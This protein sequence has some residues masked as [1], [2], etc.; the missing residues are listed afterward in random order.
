MTN[1]GRTVLRRLRGMLFVL[2]SFCACF[3]SATAEEAQHRYFDGLRERGLYLIAEDYAVSRLSGNR[4]LPDERAILTAEL[5]HT[6]I[7][8]GALSTGEQRHELWQEAERLL[9]DFIVS[10]PQ[11][12]R[13]LLVQAAA[14]MLPARMAETLAWEL[15]VNPANRQTAALAQQHASEAQRRLSLL[16]T[17]ITSN[18][19]KSSPQDQADGALSSEEALELQQEVAYRLAAS[20]FI[21][22]STFPPGPDRAGLLIETVEQFKDLGNSRGDSIWT[23]RATI[24]RAKLARLDGDFREAE[25]LLRS[26]A[27]TGSSDSLEDEILAEQVRVQ[28]AQGHPDQGLQDVTDRIR[29]GVP[30]AD[31]LRAVAVEG[32]LAAW[33]IAGQKGETEFQQELLREAQG[34]YELTRGKWQQLTAYRLREVQQDLELGDELAALVREANEYF[35]AGDLTKSSEL[36]GNAAAIAHRQK[37]ADL[38]V[39]YAMT[40]GSIE[41]QA[42]NWRVAASNFEQLVIMYSQHAK[43]GDADLMKCYCLGQLYLNQ[44]SQESRT[45]YESAL[46]EHRQK[47]SGS[48]SAAE[49]TWML[50]AHQ[51]HRLQW[52]EALELYRQIPPA[53]ARYDAAML[54]VIILYEKILTRLREL[55]GDVTEWEDRILQEIV[56]IEER[57]PQGGLLKS[58]EQCQTSLR[59]AQLLLQHRDRYYRIADQWLLR[60]QATIAEQ[61]LQASIRNLE[62][63]LSWQQVERGA[64]QLRIVS[65]AGQEQL[66]EARKV[67]LVLQKTDPSTMLGILLGLTEMTAKV[68]PRYQVELGHLQIEAINRLQVD[69]AE[70]NPQQ[71]RMLD[72]SHAEAFVAIGNLLE[73]AGIY[74]LLIA[75]APRDERLIRKVIQVRTKRGQSEDFIRAKHWWT[76]IEQLHFPGTAPWIESRLNIAQLDIRLGDPQRARKLLGVT[77][78]LYPALGTPELKAEVSTL[79]NEL[80]AP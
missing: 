45:D 24:Q 63:G 66:G 50:A 28:L 3:A 54:R 43:A 6:L 30:L 77:Q 60:I 5:A 70:L 9:Q 1:T 48:N 75:S 40:V 65:L 64:A 32:L 16:R 39:T 74:E 8:H 46:N 51:E 57:F 21:F 62:L 73:A 58:L 37:K 35:Q 26:A 14:A 27:R 76:K 80:K 2:L 18:K 79:L 29:E 11:N 56:R 13:L 55:Q 38:A 61:R 44:P 34:H 52:T 42:Q 7:A 25:S 31:E 69:R 59:V 78:A 17:S 71:Q 72:G 47:F 41:V 23:V 15:E 10:N 20:N 53:H 67:M 68:D 12:P 33:K 4:L 49:A 36:Y 22:A 19:A